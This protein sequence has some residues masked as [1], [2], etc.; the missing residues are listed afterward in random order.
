MHRGYLIWDL[1]N[2][3]SCVVK[4]NTY[5]EYKRN[6][7]MLVSTNW[8]TLE[9]LTKKFLCMR[10]LTVYVIQGLPSSENSCFIEELNWWEPLG[11][12]LLILLDRLFPDK[13]THPAK[14]SALLS[15]RQHWFFLVCGYMQIWEIVAYGLSVFCY[16]HLVKYNNHQHKKMTCSCILILANCI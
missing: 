2:S 5:L 1:G 13:N 3:E 16:T 10:P 4:G 12:T 9:G 8:K 14:F 6:W 11:S 15:H 7:Q